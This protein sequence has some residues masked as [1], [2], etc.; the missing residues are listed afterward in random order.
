MR[1]FTL[2]LFA[3]L[4]ISTAQPSFAKCLTCM[5][6][7]QC[8]GGVTGDPRCASGFPCCKNQGTCFAPPRPIAGELT[9]ASVEITRPAAPARTITTSQQKLARAAKAPASHTR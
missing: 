5:D 2:V 4:I 6:E 8:L 7:C 9:I 1:K 3:L